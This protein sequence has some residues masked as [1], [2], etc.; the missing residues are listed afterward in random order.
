MLTHI[1]IS[2]FAIVE[3]LDLDIPGKLTVIT[4]ETGAGKSIMID[5]L[6]LALG[7]RADSGSVRHGAER[8]EILATFDIRQIPAAK[9]WLQERDLLADD[10]CILRRVITADGR[11]RAYVNGTPSPVQGLKEL[12]EMLVS[13]HGQH[14]HQSLLKKETHRE[15]LDEFAGLQATARTVADAWR[16]WQQ[17]Q[18]EYLHFRDHAKELQD[19]ADLLRFQLAELEELKPQEG[20]LAELEQEHKRL[21][22]VD[23]LI[24]QGQQ[25][26]AGLAEGDG[27]LADQAQSVLHLLRD[28]LHEDNSL[29]ELVELVESARI[30]LEEAGSSLR[31]YVDHLDINPERYQEVDRR[32]SAYIHLAR[33]HRED[34][35][36]LFVLWQNLSDELASIDGG[37]DKLAQLEKAA[38][39]AKDVYLAEA[40]RLT[41][42]RGKDAKKLSKLITEKVQPLGMPGAEFMVELQ[43]LD[44]GQTSPHG[45]EQVE[46][47]VRTNPG[48]PAKP[49]N[50]VASGGELSR[51]SLAIQVACAAKTNVATL[52][53]DEVDVGIGGA[54]AQI[55]GKLL[56]ELGQANQVLCVT[57]LPQVAAQGH[58]HLHVNKQTRR[59]QTHT[60]I[61]KLSQ[62]E[63]VSEIA[64]MLG[65]LKITEQTLAHAR[66]MIA[67]SQG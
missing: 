39:A 28:M 55:V 25:A 5:A 23:S 8:A 22:N 44:D 52:V 32:L 35:H 30:Q 54:V 56:R 16:N 27:A 31:H 58:T 67:E 34:P 33:K 49:L 21:S 17:K 53:F 12:G 9:A 19:R 1:K 40:A 4:G 61:S 46:F 41:K 43:A 37:D 57:H 7:D 29:K 51:I 15:L 2:N 13:I 42:A 66:E 62:D 6:G 26:L 3:E 20:E 45:L 59:N 50:K 18:A 24:S 47:I 64:R 60:D 10:E 36:Q 63:T 48:Q 38:N 14:E 11:S 65:G